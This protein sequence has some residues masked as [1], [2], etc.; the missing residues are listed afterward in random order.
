LRSFRSSLVFDNV[1]IEDVVDFF[2]VVIRDASGGLWSGLSPMRSS[3]ATGSGDMKRVH[4]ASHAE[5]NM[6]MADG[7]ARKK[8]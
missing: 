2:G 8:R 6:R 7:K 4:F 3:S 5:M 1:V